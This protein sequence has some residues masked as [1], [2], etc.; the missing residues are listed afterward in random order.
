MLPPEPI[1]LGNSLFWLATVTPNSFVHTNSILPDYHPDPFISFLGLYHSLILDRLPYHFIQ[2][3]HFQPIHISKHR[4]CNCEPLLCSVRPRFLTLRHMFRY[5]SSTVE[6]TYSYEHIICLLYE[7]YLPI[8]TTNGTMETHPSCLVNKG[9]AIAN[10][11]AR[12]QISL[13]SVRQTDI[14]LTSVLT[15]SPISQ[16]SWSL[17]RS[18][19]SLS[20]WGLM[21]RSLSQHHLWDGECVRRS[22]ISCPH[23]TWW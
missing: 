18:I 16:H 21:L 8:T 2:S 10:S 23:E 17:K 12:D 3:H 14:W 15:E 7:T 1:R 22:M 5:K 19:F 11:I 20:Y 6:W 4:T 9:S 13:N